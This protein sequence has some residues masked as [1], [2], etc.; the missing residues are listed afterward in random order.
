ME[1]MKKLLSLIAAAVCLTGMT[2]CGFAAG[3]AYAPG[4]T[5]EAVF[6]VAENPNHAV[7]AAAELE[8]DHGALELAA[9][10]AFQGDRLYIFGD[11]SEIAAGTA[12]RATFRILEGAAE[13]ELKI[14]LK[15]TEAYDFNEQAAGGLTFTGAKVT[16]GQPQAAGAA[17][18]PGGSGEYEY[19]IADGGVKIVKYLGSAEEAV[20]PDMIEGYPVVSISGRAFSEQPHIKS[21]TI[22]ESVTFMS[23]MAFAG[24]REVTLRITAGSYA[25][26]YCVGQ[27]ISYTTDLSGGA[28]ASGGSGAAEVSDAADYE[29]EIENG[30]AKILKYTGSGTETAV[31]QT[32][33]GYPVT[34]IS[35]RAFSECPGLTSVS[36]PDTVLFISTTAF[37]GCRKVMVTVGK[38]SYAEQ[39]C[40]K[41]GIAYTTR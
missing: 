6:T 23:T 13:G 39:Y 14:G 25:E 22:P 29:Y 20:V 36:I 38:G 33:E 35:G 16:V 18:A 27:G 28:G 12:F 11:L 4:S 26:K 21:V 10:G 34:Y 31:P 37:A 19:K 1:R 40:Q 41:K 2:L 30:E 5:F 9:G 17:G 32:I 15:T 7:A 24:C 3:E 8:Y